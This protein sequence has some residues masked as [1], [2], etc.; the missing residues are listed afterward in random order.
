MKSIITYINEKMIYT[1]ETAFK[2]K[3][4][5]E[6]WEE[7]YDIIYQLIKERGN[8]GDFN[9]IDVSK[10]TDMAELF[11]GMKDFNGDISEWDVSNVKHMEFMF[12]GCSSFNR[13]ISNWVLNHDTFTKQMFE[14]CPIEEK[15]KPKYK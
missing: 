1:K 14:K 4:H 13:D 10:I 2:H 3:Y 8:E 5:P 15:H 11:E 6:T 9:D 7:L 12:R